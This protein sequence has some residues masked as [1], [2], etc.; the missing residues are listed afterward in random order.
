MSRAARGGEGHAGQRGVREEN[1]TITN[2]VQAPLVP[3]TL[4][5]Q[6]HRWIAQKSTDSRSPRGSTRSTR[7]CRT[8]SREHRPG[9]WR[10]PGP[11][12]WTPSPGTWLK[13]IQATI[14]SMLLA[15]SRRTTC[16]SLPINPGS[17]TQRAMIV[18]TAGH[19]R[20]ES[21]LRLVIAA[22]PRALRE[23]C[24]RLGR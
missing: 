16:K 6:H 9:T 24:L 20:I 19:G 8:A 23:T 12:R 3:R 18:W 21:S 4:G 14:S 17:W 15:A 2:S 22:D 13:S 11:L 1:H 10:V 7:Y 5:M